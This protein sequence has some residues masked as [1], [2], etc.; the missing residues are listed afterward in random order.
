MLVALSD[1]II[2]MKY[3]TSSLNLVTLKYKKSLHLIIYVLGVGC[4]ILAVYVTVS[5]GTIF[6]KLPDLLNQTSIEIFT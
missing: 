3:L 6:E 1:Y 4:V 2:A 5:V